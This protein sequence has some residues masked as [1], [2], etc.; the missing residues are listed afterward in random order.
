MQRS[1]RV[2]AGRPPDPLVVKNPKHAST[3]LAPALPSSAH[4]RSSTLYLRVQVPGT[5]F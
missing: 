5:R 3:A 2:G 4:G 1:C